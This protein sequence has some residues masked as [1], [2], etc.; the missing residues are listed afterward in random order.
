MSAVWLYLVLQGGTAIFEGW[1][2][3]PVT[4]CVYKEYHQPKSDRKYVFYIHPL[5]NCPPY[6]KHY[7]EAED[8]NG[9][10]ALHERWERA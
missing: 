2:V 6:V 9:R 4:V 3:V 8:G 1:R 5:A 7:Q 10:Q